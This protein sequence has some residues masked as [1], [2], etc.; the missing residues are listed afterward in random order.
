VIS[1][2]SAWATRV[3]LHFHIAILQLL[4]LP[5]RPPPDTNLALT[6]RVNRQN[7]HSQVRPQVDPRVSAPLYMVSSQAQ[8]RRYR[9]SKLF[10]LIM[11]F[12]PASPKVLCETAANFALSGTS[13]EVSITPVEPWLWQKS[14]S[15]RLHAA[16]QGQADTRSP[17]RAYSSRRRTST[18]PSTATL[19]PRTS[20]LSRPVSKPHVQFFAVWGFI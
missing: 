18:Y 4:L 16:P 7:A 19:I 11:S 14:K 17:Q 10:R 8:L 3:A 5:H 6:T 1:L 9:R 13:S 20:S 12:L 15:S 2:T